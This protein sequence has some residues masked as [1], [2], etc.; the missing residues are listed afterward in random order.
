MKKQVGLGSLIAEGLA[1]SAVAEQVGVSLEE[2]RIWGQNDS[3]FIAELNHCRRVLWETSV[4]QL[5]GVVPHALPAIQEVLT[6]ASNS[7]RW[8]AGWKL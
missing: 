6:D 2:I 8:R 7:Q 4:D 5:R 1:D 3:V